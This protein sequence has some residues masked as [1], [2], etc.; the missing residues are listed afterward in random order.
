[1]TT[2]TDTNP[3]PIDPETK[4][5]DPDRLAVDPQLSPEEKHAALEQWAFAV[6]SRLDAMSEGM[7]NVDDRAYAADV[8]MMQR[9][10]KLL[11]LGKGAGP[12][13]GAA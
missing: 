9:L 12:Q 3:E 10:E 5:K 8:A 2:S 6:R 1:M 4:Y 11:A 7:T 13:D